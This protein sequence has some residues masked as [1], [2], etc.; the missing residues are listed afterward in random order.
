M[1]QPVPLPVS[2]TGSAITYQ[3]NAQPPLSD[4]SEAV[5]ARVTQC[6]Q[7]APDPFLLVDEDSPSDEET[8][9]CKRKWRTIKSGKLRTRDSHVVI[10]IK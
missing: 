5:H 8:S 6:L 10:R 9:P 1:G 2:V 4:V 7:G 3:E